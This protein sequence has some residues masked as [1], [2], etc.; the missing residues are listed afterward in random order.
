V[1]H[2]LAARDGTAAIHVTEADQRLR[3]RA[4]RGAIKLDGLVGF[5]VKNQIRGGGLNGHGLLLGRR[6]SNRA[7]V[8]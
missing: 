7:V 8:L 6:R 5:A 1:H 3:R 2:E 4:Q